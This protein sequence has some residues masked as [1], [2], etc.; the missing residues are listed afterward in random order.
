MGSMKNTDMIQLKA[1]TTENTPEEESNDEPMPCI[2]PNN[3]TSAMM[4]EYEGVNFEKVLSGSVSPALGDIAD[5][6][7]PDPMTNGNGW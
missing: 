1:G 4:F 3:L 5:V 6:L 7:Y 2:V